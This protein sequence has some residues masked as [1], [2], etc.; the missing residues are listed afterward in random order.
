[1]SEAKRVAV[2]LFDAAADIVTVTVDEETIERW[3]KELDAPRYRC[4]S[5]KSTNVE[6]V[7]WVCPNSDEVGEVFGTWNQQDTSFCN[8]CEARGCIEEVSDG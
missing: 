7:M 4:S 3:R 8:D 5:C 6:H 2:E 1:M